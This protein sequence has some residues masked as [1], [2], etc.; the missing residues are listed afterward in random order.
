MEKRRG[1]GSQKLLREVQIRLDIFLDLL[2]PE[3]SSG[4]PH[5]P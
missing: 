5:L 3:D 1:H 4:L 2:A